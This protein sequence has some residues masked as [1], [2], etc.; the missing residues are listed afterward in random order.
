MPEQSYTFPIAEK[1]AIQAKRGR[2]RFPLAVALFMLFAIFILISTSAY[3]G[4]GAR[5]LD[6]FDGMIP[7][8]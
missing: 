3:I 8:P 2:R 5:S 4:H 1:T 6:N 7:L